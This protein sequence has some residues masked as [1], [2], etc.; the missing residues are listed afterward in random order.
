[1]PDLSNEKI[2]PGGIPVKA[3]FTPDVKWRLVE[4]FGSE[5]FTEMDDG[6]LLFS[7]DYTDMENLVTWMLTFG[8]KAEVLEPPEVRSA[9]R[10]AAEETLKNHMEDNG[11]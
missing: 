3:L 11:V 8:G 9:I 4:E 1:M 10:K 7:A 6:R 5:C 2:F